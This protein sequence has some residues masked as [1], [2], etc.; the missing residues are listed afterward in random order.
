M[1]IACYNYI[2]H[3]F[4]CYTRDRRTACRSNNSF[5]LPCEMQHPTKQG[6][7]LG[8]TLNLGHQ[9]QKIK[10]KERDIDKLLVVSNLAF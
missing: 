1:L 6:A 8:L 7:Y 3:L 2:T 5:P 4:V 9:I 10:S